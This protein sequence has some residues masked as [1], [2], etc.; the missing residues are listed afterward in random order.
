MNYIVLAT[1]NLNVLL[2][3]GT[4]NKDLKPRTI[5][6]QP[7]YGP[8]RGLEDMSEKEIRALEAHY[9]CPIRRPGSDG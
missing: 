6:F 3:K 7:M 4:S 8:A 1:Q 2:G 9:G 5:Y